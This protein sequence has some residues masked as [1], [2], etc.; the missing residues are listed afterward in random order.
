MADLSGNVTMLAPAN[1]GCLGT[2]RWGP[3][4]SLSFCI[5]KAG[6]CGTELVPSVGGA[7]RLIGFSPVFS[8][9]GS[10]IVYVQPVNP[11]EPPEVYDLVAENTDGS[12]HRVL[13]SGLTW[14]PVV[15]FTPDQQHVL[16]FNGPSG[17]QLVSIADGTATDLGPGGFS[18]LTG[19]TNGRLTFSPDGAEVLLADGNAL[20]AVDLTT[21]ARREIVQV[22]KGEYAGLV[23]FVYSQRVLYTHNVDTTPPGSDVLSETEEV[24]IAD[25]TNDVVLM[26]THD[27][28]CAPFGISPDASFVAI[29][30]GGAAIVALDG[31]VLSTV[32]S[33]DYTAVLGISADAS[34]IVDPRR[35]RFRLLP[36]GRRTDPKSRRNTVRRD[37]CCLR[38]L[39]RSAYP[40]TQSRRTESSVRT[41]EKKVATASIASCKAHKLTLSGGSRRLGS[42]LLLLSG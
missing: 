24:H 29:S 20:V 19:D 14:D 41:H 26:P 35:G 34:G 18:P 23:A 36:D 30:C 10:V 1:T 40:A 28:D 11:C 4:D 25:G 3:A 39:V 12:N 38:P 2:P 16:M 9:D 15:A 17:T 8:D 22:P 27:G 13:V 37:R 21:A 32:D 7:S 33:T 5:D 31:T 6:V 42:E